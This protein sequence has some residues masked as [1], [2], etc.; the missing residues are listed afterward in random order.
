MGH[1]LDFAY[2]SSASP[3]IIHTSAYDAIQRILVLTGPAGVGKTATIRAL[4]HDLNYEVIEW[5]MDAEDR[6]TSGDAGT[7][8]IKL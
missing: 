5:V 8:P 1:S 6:W 7:C 2:V 4:S 3:P